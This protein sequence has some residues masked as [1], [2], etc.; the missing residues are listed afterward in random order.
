MSGLVKIWM[1]MIVILIFIVMIPFTFDKIRESKIKVGV[2]Y[3]YT[4]STPNPF[5]KPYIK[6]CRVINI[7]DRYVQYID[8]AYND[9][10]SMS[11]GLFVIGTEELK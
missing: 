6:Y 7:K 4:M 11:I 9:T 10:S 5:E 1:I 8:S 3:K 2:T